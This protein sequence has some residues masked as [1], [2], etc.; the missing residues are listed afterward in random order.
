MSLGLNKIE[1]RKSTTEKGKGMRDAKRK[2]IIGHGNKIEV[3]YIFKRDG[4]PKIVAD[5][6]IEI[7]KRERE[8]VDK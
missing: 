2:I 6:K 8:K 1:R 3:V 4:E 5:P 7:A